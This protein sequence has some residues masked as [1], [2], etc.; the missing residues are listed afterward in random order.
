AE[1]LAKQLGVNVKL[2]DIIYHAVDDVKEMM[3]AI[4]P[5]I[6]EEKDLGAAEVLQTF[7]SSH[8]GVIAGCK[9][10]EGTIARGNHIRVKRDGKVIWRGQISSIRREKDD[11]REVTKGLECG[12]VLQSFREAEPGD[13][14]E[15]FEIIY[16]EQNL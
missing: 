13:I 5:K 1:P 10:T 3:R 7:K 2:H 11:V 9:I 6:A 4:L 16:L 15:S 12:I 8:L 14:L